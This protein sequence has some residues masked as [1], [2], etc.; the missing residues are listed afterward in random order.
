MDVRLS[1]VFAGDGLPAGLT[2]NEAP[3]LARLDREGLR[4]DLTTDVALATGRGPKLRGHRGVMLAGDTRWLTEDVRRQLRSFVAGGGT[5]ASLGTASLRAEVRQTP[6][7]LTD[8]TR[9]AAEDLFG[10]RIRRV[11]ERT[12]DLQILE[13]D[14]NVQLF[15]GEEG[16]FPAVEAW[17]ATASVGSEARLAS[18][19]VTPDGEEV[20][21]AARFGRGLVIRTGIP[22][23]ATRL[24]EDETSAELLGRIWT[25][26]R[27][28]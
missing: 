3:L 12:V 19:A 8:P 17:E 18:T 6:R 11:R 15:A 2:E 10:A 25:L 7:R 20:I 16:L 24:S 26:L 28:G 5:L 1:R 13:D 9:P 14:P 23:F 22:A 21:V 27:T 4:Y